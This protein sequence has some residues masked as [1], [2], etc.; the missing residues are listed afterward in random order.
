MINYIKGAIEFMA[1]KA[2][3]G[4]FLTT[5]GDNHIMLHQAAND[6]FRGV[7]IICYDGPD[8]GK[9]VVILANGDNPAVYLIAEMSKFLLGSNGIY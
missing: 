7:Y 1:A 6:G 9:G 8:R 3:L 5:A 2:S 4:T